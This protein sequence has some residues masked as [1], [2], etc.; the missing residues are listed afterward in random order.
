MRYFDTFIVVNML[1]L[2]LIYMQDILVILRDYWFEWSTIQSRKKAFENVGVMQGYLAPELI[3]RKRFRTSGIAGEDEAPDFFREAPQRLDE[4]MDF[5]C[6]ELHGIIDDLHT[7]IESSPTVQGVLQSAARL[8]A[9]TKTQNSRISSQHG[10]MP[11]AALLQKAKQVGVENREKVQAVQERKRLAL[12]KNNVI[13]R[14]KWSLEMEWKHC[15]DVCQCSNPDCKM[16]RLYF[17][18]ICKTVMKS[19][20]RKRHV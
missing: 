13:A 3:S 7:F 4:S 18:E 1:Y 12:E 9:K 20:C 5:S 6:D 14:D 2:V 10:I 8:A 19:Q 16:S 17:C 11:L 15:K